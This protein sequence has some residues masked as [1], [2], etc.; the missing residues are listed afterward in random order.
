M[1]SKSSEPIIG[2]RMSV[3]ASTVLDHP[4]HTAH[5]LAHLVYG[6][7]RPRWG[8]VYDAFRRAERAGLVTGRWHGQR[9]LYYRGP[10]ASARATA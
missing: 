1:S 8:Y 3:I 7:R 10:A 5:Y 6:Q 9:K 4:G 2:Y